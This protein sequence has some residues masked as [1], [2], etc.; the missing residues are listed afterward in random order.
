MAQDCEKVFG[1]PGLDGI[2][3]FHGEDTMVADL[4]KIKEEQDARIKFKGYYDV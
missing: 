4:W 3:T 1:D 2:L